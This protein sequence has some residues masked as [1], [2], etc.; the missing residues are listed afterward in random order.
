MFLSA[1]AF[2]DK[3][4]P[5]YG[6]VAL[7][8]KDIFFWI[9]AF[10]MAFLVACGG[11]GGKGKVSPQKEGVL[12]EKDTGQEVILTVGQPLELA[13]YSNPS[14]GYQWQLAKHPAPAV[15][16]LK[17]NEFKRPPGAAQLPPGTGGTEY[18]RF[19]AKGPGKTTLELY[20]LR[21]W[22]KIPAPG[23][24]MLHVVVR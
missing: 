4:T 19:A 13:L 11:G 14:T 22:E 3:L 18:W 16:E 6:E 20:Y 9:L 17:G 24:F 8:M 21:P 7:A 15:L 2:D 10:I 23:S 12:T 5:V 1:V